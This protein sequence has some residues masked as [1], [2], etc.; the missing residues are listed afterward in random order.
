MKYLLQ[1][2]PIFPFISSSITGRSQKSQ[3]FSEHIFCSF[4]I[5]L[6]LI[7]SCRANKHF[8]YHIQLST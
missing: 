8:L 5:T 1:Q 4:H 7:G 2:N 3:E 6:S